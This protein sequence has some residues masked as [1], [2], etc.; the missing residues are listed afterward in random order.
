M[1]FRAEACGKVSRAKV[2]GSTSPPLEDQ[3]EIESGTEDK[4]E[5]RFAGEILGRNR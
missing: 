4:E 1:S 5:G 3:E 2:N